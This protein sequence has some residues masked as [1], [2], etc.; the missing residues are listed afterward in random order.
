MAHFRK[1]SIQLLDRKCPKGN[2]LSYACYNLPH[3]K[4]SFNLLELKEWRGWEK[5]VLNDA[6]SCAPS[7]AS[8]GDGPGNTY[9]NK[10]KGVA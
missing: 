4:D 6:A 10:L 8:D 3:S 7:S 5:F 9:F 2:T 1:N